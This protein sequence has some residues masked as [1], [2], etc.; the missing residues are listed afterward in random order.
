MRDVGAS[1]PLYPADLGFS[2]GF[3]VGKSLNLS[4]GK[5]EVNHVSYDY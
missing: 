1:A 2:I 3:G 5:F 4:Y